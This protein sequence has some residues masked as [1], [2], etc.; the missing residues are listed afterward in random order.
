MNDVVGK[1]TLIESNESDRSQPA[2]TRHPDDL[3]TT[4]EL[5]AIYDKS[6]RTLESW[7]LKGIGPKYIRVGGRGVLYR[8]G[9]AV[10]Y[11]NSRRFSSTSEERA[12]K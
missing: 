9:D 2:Q 10:E 3:L 8:W 6:P 12:A 7:R 4:S 11:H 5:S 1:M